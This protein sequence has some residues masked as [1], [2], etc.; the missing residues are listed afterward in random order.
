MIQN[1]YFVF[2]KKSKELFI[3][4]YVGKNIERAS[5]EVRKEVYRHIRRYNFIRHQE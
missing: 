1:Y 2:L 4:R 5:T 3:H